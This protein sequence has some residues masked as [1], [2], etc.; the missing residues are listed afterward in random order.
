MTTND[1][2]INELKTAARIAAHTLRLAA[3]NPNNPQ[4]NREAYKDAADE[5]NRTLE[6]LNK[7][8]AQ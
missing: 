1:K 7:A 6:N 2:A 5:L 4:E 3:N 8:Q